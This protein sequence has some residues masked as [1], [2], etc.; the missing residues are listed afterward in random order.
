MGE[1]DRLE[2]PEGRD[3][4]VLALTA[5]RVRETRKAVFGHHGLTP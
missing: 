4:N 5:E 2:A 3:E 1:H